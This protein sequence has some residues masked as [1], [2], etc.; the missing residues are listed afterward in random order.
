MIFFLSCLFV[1]VAAAADKFA[2]QSWTLTTSAISSHILSV[3]WLVGWCVSWWRNLLQLSLLYIFWRFFWL[4]RFF[5]LSQRRALITH[6]HKQRW[7]N[8]FRYFFVLA[9]SLKFTQHFVIQIGLYFAAAYTSTSASS[10]LFLWPHF[11]SVSTRTIKEEEEREKK[12]KNQQQK[13]AKRHK[14]AKAV[15]KI[16][17]F[18]TFGQEK[19]ASKSE[20]ERERKRKDS[21]NSKAH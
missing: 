18:S 14:S 3:G 19:V 16:N 5:A 13:R 9:T 2:K 21:L 4:R 17:K 7:E 12:R 1:V 15:L 11:I 6:T 20:S 8:N 10:S